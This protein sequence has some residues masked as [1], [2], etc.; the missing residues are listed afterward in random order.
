MSEAVLRWS[1]ESSELAAQSTS[2]ITILRNSSADSRRAWV[3]VFLHPQSELAPVVIFLGVFLG[4]LPLGLSQKLP[5]VHGDED[6]LVAESALYFL[7]DC[8]G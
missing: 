1:V 8:L 6:A 2:S 3:W 4:N 5:E 7:N